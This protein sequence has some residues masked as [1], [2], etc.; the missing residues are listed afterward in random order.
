MDKDKQKEIDDKLIDF[1]IQ[2]NKN[3][4]GFSKSTVTIFDTTI[5]YEQLVTVD[6]DKK[7]CLST[8]PFDIMNM[9]M[10]NMVC[11]GGQSW[12]RVYPDGRICNADNGMYCQKCKCGSNLYDKNKLIEKSVILCKDK[13]C[14]GFCALPIPKCNISD[15]KYL[16]KNKA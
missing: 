12:F 11:M 3:L 9:D 13:H 2:Y 8:G 6:F 10:Y 15:M 5:D 4:T 14:L 7:E 1:Y 16:I